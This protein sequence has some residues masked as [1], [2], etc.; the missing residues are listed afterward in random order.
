MRIVAR[1]QSYQV[2]VGLVCVCVCVQVDDLYLTMS[3][4]EYVCELRRWEVNLQQHL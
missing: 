2:H 1:R 4:N 3:M